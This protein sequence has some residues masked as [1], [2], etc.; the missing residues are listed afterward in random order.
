MASVSKTPLTDRKGR[1]YWRVQVSRG[2]GKA[3]FETKFYW[4][5]KENGDPVSKNKAES[6][7]NDF[8]IGYERDCKDGK[9]L[10]RQQKKEVEAQ[11]A[12]EA[13]EAAKAAAAIKTVKQYA[14]L[15]FLPK[16]A[17]EC[18]ENTRA[19]YANALSNYIVPKFGDYKLP[20][21]TS[22]MLSA[23]MLELLQKSDLSHSSILGVH[24]TLNQ[25]FRQAYFEELIDRNPM[26]KVMRPK[27]PKD[28][29]KSTEPEAFTTEELKIILDS[30]SAEPLK[31]Q[32]MIRLMID[33]GCRKGEACGLKWESVDFDNCEIT[34]RGNLCYTSSKGVYEA[35]PKT[36]QVRT[37]PVSAE[38]I[39]FLK[40]LNAEQE[41][42]RQKRI[43]RLEKEGKPLD[44]NK[45]K[46]PEYVFT[47]KGYADPMNPQSPTRYFA[48]FGK[49]YGINNFHP[50]KLRHTFASVAITN[51]ADIASVSEI[52][53]HADKATTLK[54]Y[55][56]AD[57][58]SMRKASEVFRKAFETEKQ[59]K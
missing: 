1:K 18:A 32:T 59:A 53:G 47:E 21:I 9:V 57:R 34:I 4:P 52:L 16:K 42:S 22:A 3:P 39:S 37:V 33:T 5:T 7:L 15:V 31:W 24:I 50:H 43:K 54:M 12:K 45:I 44:I 58:E 2:T 25:L 55:T 19:Y 51:G 35:L 27:K 13:E 26:D 38:T 8:V 20:E 30:L 11:R 29:I 41:E 49:K 28:D 14:E 17:L 46:V 10:T 56:H 6:L 23:F 48:K 40:R 36:G